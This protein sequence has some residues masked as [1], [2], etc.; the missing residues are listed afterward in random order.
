MISRFGTN[1]KS[2][3]KLFA[4][5]LLDP[6][7][8]LFAHTYNSSGHIIVHKFSLPRQHITSFTTED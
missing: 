2:H 4:L 6:R 5:Q 1:R 8:R 7:E 3:L